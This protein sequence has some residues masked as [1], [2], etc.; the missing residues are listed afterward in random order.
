MQ[1]QKQRDLS[2]YVSGKV[3]HFV[4][5]YKYMW[6]EAIWTL[7]RDVTTGLGIAIY[8]QDVISTADIS[9]RLNFNS[10]YF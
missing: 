9:F 10:W 8:A 1:R 5:Q 6:G 4:D 3:E 7:S 2:T